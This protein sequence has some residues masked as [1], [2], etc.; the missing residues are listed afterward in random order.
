VQRPEFA[1]FPVLV[2]ACL[3]DAVEVSSVPFLEFLQADPGG[4]SELW[5]RQLAAVRVLARLDPGALEVLHDRLSRHP[6]MDIRALVAGRRASVDQEVWRE[7]RTGYELVW[8]PPGSFTMGSPESEKERYDYEGP[9][10]EVHVRGFL[11]GRYPVTN[12]QYAT[13]LKANPEVSEPEFWADRKFNEAQQPVVG[14]SWDDARRFAE[15]AG[16]RLPTEAEWEYA[17]RAGTTTRFYTGD[18]EEDLGRAGWY[19]ANAGGQPHAVGGKEPNKFGL[20]D[21][22]G[23]VWEWVEDDWH[24]SYDGAPNDGRAWIDSP[25]RGSGRVLRGG[26]WINDPRDCRAAF[27]YVY[28]PHERLGTFGF[29]VVSSGLGPSE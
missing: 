13:F 29:R 28:V 6:S 10:H 22:H 12:A 14:V 4:K 27:R 16:M 8:I 18:K 11:M 21:M 19:S 24:R 1:H 23:N 17:C 9:E 2:D 25:K 7:E 26:A 20:Y 5:Q 3:E 15:W